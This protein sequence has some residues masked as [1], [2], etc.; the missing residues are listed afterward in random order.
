[1]ESGEKVEFSA[2][3]LHRPSKIRRG[4][5][6]LGHPS[7]GRQGLHSRGE[8]MIGG[9]EQSVRGDSPERI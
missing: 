6:G 9:W 4:A 3:P 8:R 5:D 1:M 2:V 7:D